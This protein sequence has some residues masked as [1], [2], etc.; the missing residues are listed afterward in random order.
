[1]NLEKLIPIF[2]PVAQEI[3]GLLMRNKTNE[4]VLADKIKQYWSL[5]VES[6]RFDGL[7]MKSLNKKL[8]QVAMSNPMELRK[9]LKI[10]KSNF[11]VKNNPSI[12]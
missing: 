11:Q 12:K 9:F 3:M 10:L 8:K 5:D 6:T 2:D 4:R 1:M 7:F